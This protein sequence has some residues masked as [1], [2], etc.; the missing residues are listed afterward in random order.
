MTYIAV[1]HDGQYHY[2][3]TPFIPQIDNIQCEL[4]DSYESLLSKYEE[5]FN[6]KV[7]AVKG[8]F[9]VKESSFRKLTTKDPATVWL[10]GNA[11]ASQNTH[12]LRCCASGS[13]R[14]IGQLPCSGVEYCETITK[15]HELYDKA[16]EMRKALDKFRRN[17]S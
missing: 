8:I 17:K 16:D 2:D 4:S 10:I 5:K 14:I 13:E 11:A 12:Q 1:F 7:N 3:S 9:I 6:D 15:Y